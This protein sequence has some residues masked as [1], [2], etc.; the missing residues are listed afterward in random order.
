MTTTRKALNK[1]CTMT[2][3]RRRS[4]ACWQGSSTGLEE[5]IRYSRLGCSSN[6]HPASIGVLKLIQDM[7]KKFHAPMTPRRWRRPTTP[8]WKSFSMGGWCKQKN[9][10]DGF[11]FVKISAAFTMIDVI[12]R[13]KINLIKLLTEWQIA[14]PEHFTKQ[15][16]VS[17]GWSATEGKKGYDLVGGRSQWPMKAKTVCFIF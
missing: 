16:S 9:D 6:Q 5:A 17:P 15:P 11:E 14:V 2:I 7:R 10:W 8:F 3:Y 12:N 1:S 13:S 4:R